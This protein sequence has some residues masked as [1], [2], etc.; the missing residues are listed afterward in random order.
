MKCKI[1]EKC[2]YGNNINYVCER[3]ERYYEDSFSRPCDMRDLYKEGEKIKTILIDINEIKRKFVEFE[4]HNQRDDF[5]KQ[6]YCYVLNCEHF[7]EEVRRF[8][9]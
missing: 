5:Y 6:F 1:A 8:D 9:A 3:C 7:K 2:V 4:Y